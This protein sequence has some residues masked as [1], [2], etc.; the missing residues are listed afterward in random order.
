VVIV[1]SEAYQ[2]IYE[3]FTK[4]RA[5]AASEAFFS[6]IAEKNG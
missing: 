5:S 6:K 2:F 3:R 4:D 1:G